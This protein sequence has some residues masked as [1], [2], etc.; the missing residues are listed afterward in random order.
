[1]QGKVGRREGQSTDRSRANY[2]MTSWSK[3][4]CWRVKGR[5]CNDLWLKVERGQS[6]MMMFD[7]GWIVGK[8]VQWCLTTGR[9]Q[10]KSCNEVCTKGRY[11]GKRT[12]TDLRK[13]KYDGKLRKGRC[14]G[15]LCKGRCNGGI[16]NRGRVLKTTD[17]KRSNVGSDCSKTN[18]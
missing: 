6:C 13:G 2:V 1:M 8:G 9:S 12:K 3:V 7:H 4:T 17:K 18:F 5:L 16:C 15:S 10:A 11:A 14:N